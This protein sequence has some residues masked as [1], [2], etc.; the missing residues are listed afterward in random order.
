MN[1]YLKS[2]KKKNIGKRKIECYLN[3]SAMDLRIIKT[4][5]VNYL[6]ELLKA[7]LVFQ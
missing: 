2:T 3:L 1:R 4:H 5:G 7:S 6:A